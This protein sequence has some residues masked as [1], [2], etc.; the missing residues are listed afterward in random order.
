MSGC[1]LFIQK[2]RHSHFLIS[3]N[4]R[5]VQIDTLNIV[6]ADFKYQLLNSP[7]PHTLTGYNCLPA[8][9]HPLIFLIKT[10]W[11]TQIPYPI[12][13][14]EWLALTNSSKGG[15][16]ISHTRFNLFYLLIQLS[17]L[18]YQVTYNISLNQNENTKD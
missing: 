8:Y 1:D 2:Q 16:G 11:V 13:I 10:K 15:F 5:L 3:M 4:V 17:L 18:N 12:V 6:E 14:P 9:P 7:H